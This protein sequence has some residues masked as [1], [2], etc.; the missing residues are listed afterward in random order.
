M[1]S[2]LR[3]DKIIP[4]TGVPT[5]GGGGIVQV[6]YAIKNDTQ[7]IASQGSP[8]NW[9]VD[10]SGLSLSITPK[11][12]TSKFLVQMHIGCHGTTGN[13]ANTFR[14]YR[15]STDI[16]LTAANTDSRM[17]GTVF[18]NSNNT[19]M[20][21]PVSMNVLDSPATTSAITYK[22]T[23]FTNTGTLWINRLPGDSTWNTI[24]TLTVMEVSA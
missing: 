6:K 15:G 10:I 7:S 18:Y 20:G 22:V 3:V 17:G 13:A 11:F 21:L 12:S 1:S 5:G 2:E 9:V 19:A 4:T 16:T 8:Y 14:I 23:G 24:S